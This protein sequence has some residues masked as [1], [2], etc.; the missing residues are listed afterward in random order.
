MVIAQFVTDNGKII[1]EE[2]D[3][4]WIGAVDKAYSEAV[5]L[6]SKQVLYLVIYVSNQ[7]SAS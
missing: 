6:L 2:S 5:K 7:K 4:N 3:S 1:V